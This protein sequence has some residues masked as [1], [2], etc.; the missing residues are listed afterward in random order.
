MTLS[1]FVEQI[2][3]VSSDEEE[4]TD[5]KIIEDYKKLNEKCDKVITKIKIRKKE[6]DKK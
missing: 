4:N 2:L 5:D 6:H 3:T 1:Q